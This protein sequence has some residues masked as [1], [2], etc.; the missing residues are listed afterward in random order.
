MDMMQQKPEPPL[1]RKVQ[2]WDAPTR[3]FH[4]AL[5]LL[6]GFSWLSAKKGW[7]DQHMLSGEAI[8]TLLIFRIVW[9]FVGSDSARFTRFLRSPVEALRHLAHLP[10]REPDTEIGHNAAG[11]W[12]VLGMLLLLLA[13]AGLGLFSNDDVFTD[14][15]LASLVGRKTSSQITVWHAWLFNVILAVMAL[16]VLAVLT[17]AV[18]KRHDLVRPMILGWK[19]LPERIAPPRLGHPLLAIAVLA[20]AAAAVYGI[21]HLG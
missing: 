2:V 6:I 18:V 4:W 13:Q 14:G 10:R 5:V 7:L 11:G 8:L 12:M 21:V 17:Y 19:R 15:P 1:V 9:G 16:H 20:C 3:L